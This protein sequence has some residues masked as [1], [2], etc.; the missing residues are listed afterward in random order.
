[1][2]FRSTKYETTHYIGSTRILDLDRAA[3][4]ED[5]EP[6]ESGNTDGQDLV[7]YGLGYS[8]TLVE[9]VLRRTSEIEASNPGDN[10]TSNLY[11]DE[12][13][14]DEDEE[15]TF[16]GVYPITPPYP[17]YKRSCDRSSSNRVQRSSVYGILNKHEKDKKDDGSSEDDI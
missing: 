17:L 12:E 11:C 16:I 9:E 8:D 5:S 10:E 1:M 4:P 7:E 13:E 6:E 2:L 14:F 15:D 3:A